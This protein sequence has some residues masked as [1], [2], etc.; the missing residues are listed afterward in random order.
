MGRHKLYLAFTYQFLEFDQIDAVPLKQIP[1]QISGCNPNNLS[2]GPFIV[3]N[4]RL[5]LKVNQFTTYATFGLFSRLDI[6]VAVPV[7]DVRM[8]MQTHC[9]VCSQSQPDGSVLIFTPNAATGEATGIGD[10]TVRAKTTVLKG[11]RAG[12]AL[13][14]DV[15]TPTGN[16]LN[17]LGAGAIGVR[18][19]VAFGYR[20]RVSPHADV[21]YRYNGSSILASSAQSGTALLPKVLDYSAGLDIGIVRSLSVTG[22]FLGQTFF[23]ANRVFQAVRA[24]STSLDISCD[25]TGVSP[26]CV[27]QTFITKTV[28]IGGKINPGGNLLIS[29]NVLIKLDHF[30]LHYRPAPMIGISY[31]F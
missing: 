27:G 11:E 12:L 1:L 18:P 7:L 26:S 17:F 19:F 29:A 23:N 4:S 13:G 22:D 14:V 31:T 8:G 21:A 25:P 5:D 6:S 30:G 2:C 24:P 10:V 3:T 9:S 28:A 15:R 20:A 16:E